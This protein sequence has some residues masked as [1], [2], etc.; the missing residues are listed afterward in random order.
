MVARLK[1]SRT[2]SR[3]LLREMETQIGER[4][5]RKPRVRASRVRLFQN[6]K[7]HRR[8]LWIGYTEL[9]LS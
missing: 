1:V 4:K 9:D 8:M 7:I 6:A 2:L 5:G 3:T